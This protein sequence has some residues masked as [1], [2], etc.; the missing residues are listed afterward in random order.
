MLNISEHFEYYYQQNHLKV[1]QQLTDWDTYFTSDILEDQICINGDLEKNCVSIQLGKQEGVYSCGISTSYYIGLDRLPRLGLSIYVAPKLNTDQYQVNYIEMLLEA[2]KESENFDHLDGLVVTKFEDD[3]IEI[4]NKMQPLLTPFLIAQFL[5]AVKD[6]LKR[7]LKKSYYQRQENLSGRIKGKILVGHQIRQNVFRNRLTSTVCQYQEFGVDT[8]ANRFIKH[9]LSVIPRELD[10]FP[11][12]H[13]IRKSLSDIWRYC[14]G[15]FQQVGKQSFSHLIYKENNPFYKNYNRV[16]QLGNQ[17]LALRDYN[18]ARSVSAEKCLHPPFWIDMS[19]LFELFVFKK[20]KEEF[21]GE[22]EVKYHQKFYGQ[23][24]DFIINTSTGL[25]AIVDAKYK[26]RYQNGNP[27]IADARQLAGYTRLNK[28]YEELGINDSRV[29]P[30]YFVYP[31]NIVIA[32]T[33]IKSEN[34]EDFKEDSK[35]YSKRLLNGKFRNSTM[36]KEMYLQEID[37]P[38][39]G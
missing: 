29:I 10:E 8:E 37:L 12:Q 27:S 19:K 18:I 7:G 30:A 24:P 32:E 25:K 38:L 21:S 39:V 2:L 11:A 1:F 31:G 17:L 35:L 15:G 22:G 6:L 33:E 34:E 28:I 5:S 36:Y 20:L 14:Q 16:V 13:E 3:W 23:E 9:I 4:E 26:P